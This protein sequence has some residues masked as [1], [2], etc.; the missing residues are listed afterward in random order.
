M[1]RFHRMLVPPTTFTPSQPN[2]SNWVSRQDA[3]AP[4]KTRCSSAFA[5]REQ[6]HLWVC[7]FRR[8]FFPLSLRLGVL[9][10]NSSSTSIACFRR[11]LKA[12][13][14]CRTPRRFAHS[15]AVPESPTDPRVR[16]RDGGFAFRP[17]NSNPGPLSRCAIRP[18]EFES[19]V[20]PDPWDSLPG[21]LPPISTSGAPAMT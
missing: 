11:S 3:E 6:S 10:R 12:A 4:R 7:A 16:S 15:S 5:R 1:N 20:V 8:S 21:A 18:D 19:V 2:P 9:A 14:G 17:A 13:E